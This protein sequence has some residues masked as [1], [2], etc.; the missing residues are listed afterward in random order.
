MAESHQEL[1]KFLKT[2]KDSMEEKILDSKETLEAKIDTRL[3]LIDGEMCKLNEKMNSMETKNDDITDRMNARLSALE[4]EME[5][6]A[7]IRNRSEELMKLQSKTD[8]SKKN[9]VPPAT[10][11]PIHH[12]DTHRPSLRSSWALQLEEELRQASATAD[13]PPTPDPTYTPTPRDTPKDTQNTRDRYEPLI[14]DEQTDGWKKWTDERDAREHQPTRLQ[15][16]GS[17]NKTRKPPPILNMVR[18]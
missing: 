18:R 8:G 13:Q 1:M 15:P 2:F 10:I 5:R 17:K 7:N 4:K 3:N 11:P 9:P 16:L 14:I 12:V 6:S